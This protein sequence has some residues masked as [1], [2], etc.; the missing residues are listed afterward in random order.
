[1]LKFA[2]IVDASNAVPVVDLVDSHSGANRRGF[3][4]PALPHAVPMM[5]RPL[6]EAVGNGNGNRK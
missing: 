2:D 1:M 4:H 3:H 5:I 6:V